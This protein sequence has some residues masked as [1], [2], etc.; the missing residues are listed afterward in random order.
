MDHNEE[1]KLLR[2]KLFSICSDETETHKNTY[3]K[4]FDPFLFSRV[5]SSPRV[6]TRYD[7]LD[8]DSYE[9]KMRKLKS[10][11]HSITSK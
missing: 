8:T 3:A 5:R 7:I 6:K 10:K 9:T 1:L 2:K 4:T 11:L